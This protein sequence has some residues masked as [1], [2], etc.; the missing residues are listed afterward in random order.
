MLVSTIEEPVARVLIDLDQIGVDF[1]L[2][3]SG[4]SW[5]PTSK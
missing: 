3:I 5:R 1:R 4:M 2:G